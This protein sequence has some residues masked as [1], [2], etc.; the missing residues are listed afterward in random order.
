MN[1]QNSL[2][3]DKVTI[4]KMLSSGKPLQEILCFIVHNIEN[5]CASG[6]VRG[7]IM[8]KKPTSNRLMEMLSPSL[9]K[10][11]IRELGPVDVSLYGGTSGVAAYL[12]KPIYVT[13][14]ENN[15]LWDKNRQL[16]IVHG[17]RA[18]LSIP[19]VSSNQ[20][21]LGVI[22]LYSKNIGGPNEETTKII[23]I[24]SE[25]ASLVIEELGKN[26]RQS[27]S[28]LALNRRH[29]EKRRLKKVFFEL[30]A[31]LGR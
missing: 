13:D 6:D 10:S 1:N 17:F 14:I 7:V 30:C 21:L 11:F 18:S 3:K 24:F 28:P 9:P 12:Q 15:P 31:T 4:L 20:E 25:L 19:L 8:L 2:I 29:S 5:Y 22:E 16:A 27:I 26:E 23:N